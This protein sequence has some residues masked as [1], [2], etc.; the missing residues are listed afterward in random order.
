VKRNLMEMAAAILVTG[1][2]CTAAG[3]YVA[4][5]GPLP[6]ATTREISV[7]V[8]VETKS[9]GV[10]EKTVRIRDGMTAFDAL[11]RV[12]D[13]RT[14]YWES[15]GSSTVASVAGDNLASNEGY[16]YTVNGES[17]NVGIGDCQLH[18]GDNLVI[19]YIS[20]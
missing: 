19:A 6:Y 1:F 12:A 3:M 16:V 10:I 7:N 14:Q 2:I 5:G 18:D 20:W 15:F 8:R 17:P 9:S 13:T 11:L 4:G